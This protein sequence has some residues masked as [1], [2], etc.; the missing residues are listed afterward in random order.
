MIER[1][2]PKKKLVI[3]NVL[4][5]RVMILVELG[6]DENLVMELLVRVLNQQVEDVVRKELKEDMTKRY[7]YRFPLIQA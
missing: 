1:V 7:L 4:A 2:T 6:V 5:I 3:V